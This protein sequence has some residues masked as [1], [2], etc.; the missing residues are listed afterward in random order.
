MVSALALN[1][2]AAGVVLATAIALF[3]AAA[4]AAAR[5]ASR[6]ARA[7]SRAQVDTRAASAR[8]SGSPRRPTSSASTAPSASASTA[9]STTAKALFFRTQLLARLAPNL[10]QS[11]DLPAAGRRPRGHPRHQRRARRP[12][13]GASCCCSC[14]R[15]PYGQQVQGAYQALRQ[16]L[17]F[18]ERI[19]EAARRYDDSSP[20]LRRSA[21]GAACSTIAF[22]DVSFAYDPR[23]PVLTDIELRGAGGEAIGIIG[24]SGAGKSTLVQ[25]AAAAAQPDRRA[26][27][28]Q[29]RAGRAVRARGLAPARRLRAPGTAPAARLG[30]RQHPLLPRHRRRARCERAGAPRAHPRRRSWAGR[31]ATTR[32]SAR[33]PT[34]SPAASSSA[35]ALR[36]R[37]PRSP[38]VLVLDE[39]TSALDPHSE[40]LIQESLTA[41]KQR[42]DAVHRR[43]PHV[44]ARHLRPRDGDR[45]RPAGGVRHD[46]RCCSSR[47]LLPLASLLAAGTPSSSCLTAGGVAPERSGSGPRSRRATACE[48]DPRLLHRRA[49]QERHDRAVR[50]AA[51]APADLHARRQGAV[52][53][54]RR[55]ARAHAAAP[56]RHRR[57]RSSEY[58]RAVRRRA[59]GS[60]WGR[61]RPCTCGRARPPRRSRRCARTRA[62]SRSCASP[63]ASCARCT[64]SSSR[65][66]SRPRPTS[67]RALAL[68]A[69]RREGREIPR[70]TYWPQALLYSEH[71]RYV[72]QLRR[73]HDGVRRASSV[74]VL[75]YDDFRDDNE[76]TVRQVLR[77]LGV[78]DDRPGRRR[79]GQPHASEVRSQR[80]ARGCVHAV[81]VGRGPV[82]RGDEGRDQGGHAA[83]GCAGA[84][85][86]RCSDRV[87]YAEPAAG[88]RGAD[89]A[90]CARAS[91]RGGGARR[92][93]GP[94]PLT[95]WGY[96]DV[97]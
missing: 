65:P 88:G 8:R 78:D 84:R 56:G 48:R 69:A 95:L 87:V 73:Y 39:P 22:E 61:R 44:H 12:R 80:A 51:R 74:L 86:A 60:A 85:F 33:A 7:L 83:R 96:D 89:G 31:R 25:I 66:T 42:A 38:E 24:P 11:T 64:C 67:R 19:Q 40:R 57:A 52:V 71:V 4:T 55:A 76:A 53:L 82:S 41:L 92:V 9:S 35:S 18:I 27:P 17:P 23:R 36:A 75:I 29:R 14:A 28:R 49:R 59:P 26:L 81:S 30:R 21:A 50:D 10:Y 2:V 45:R 5:W 3:A 34:P 32:S 72:E 70:H 16:S 77:F 37:S 58:A 6:R 91:A 97:D 46:R 93:P 47:H 68:E 20:A 63:R 54:R 62:S 79:R 90:S 1:L 13:S 94:R 43:P 15:A